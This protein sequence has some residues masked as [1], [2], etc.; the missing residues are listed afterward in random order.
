MPKKMSRCVSSSLSSASVLGHIMYMHQ[1]GLIVANGQRAVRGGCG[2]VGSEVGCGLGE[3]GGGESGE[4]EGVGGEG[5][6]VGGEGGDSVRP[7]MAPKGPGSVKST[8]P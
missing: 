7:V 3:G 5:E 8:S 6:G 1:R 2:E 4:S